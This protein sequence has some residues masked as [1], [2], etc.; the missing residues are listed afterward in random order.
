MNCPQLLKDLKGFRGIWLAFF[1]LGVQ[2]LFVPARAQQSD[3]AKAHDPRKAALYSAIVPGLGQA[4]NHKF[5][6]IGVVYG[7]MGGLTGFLV[8]SNA[9]MNRYQ[10]ALLLRLDGDPNTIDTEFSGL[11]DGAVRSQRDFYRRNRDISILGLVAVY[12]LQII[13][14]NVDAHLREFKINRDLS[15]HLEPSLLSVSPNRIL[16]LQGIQ[17]SVRF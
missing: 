7:A 8:V 1:I 17:I 12:A 13:D 5:W 14:A 3:S 2:G 15:L 11:T 4:Y 9:N 6:K 10:E 16:P